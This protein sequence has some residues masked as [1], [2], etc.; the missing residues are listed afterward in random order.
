MGMNRLYFRAFRASIIGLLAMA[1]LLFVPSGTFDYWQAYL[2][3]AVFAGASAAIMVYLAIKDPELLER[4]MKAGRR[5]KSR[6]PKRSSWF[7]RCWDLSRYWWFRHWTVALCGRQFRRTSLSSG[8]SWWRSDFLL[9]Y[10]VIR[11]NSY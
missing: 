10:F 5:R 3:M 11:E 6:R 9:V 4:R 7:S 1:A 8:T 2:F